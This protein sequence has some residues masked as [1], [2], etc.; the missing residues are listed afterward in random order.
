MKNKLD[1]E[2]KEILE[3][4][5]SGEWQQVPDMEKEIKRHIEIAK[6]THRKDKRINIRISE[7]DLGLIKRAAIKEGIPSADTGG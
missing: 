3:S 2:E 7:R 6:A 1:K 4:F 5:E